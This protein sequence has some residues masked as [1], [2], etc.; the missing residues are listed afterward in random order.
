MSLFL[1]SPLLQVLT[2]I[3]GLT[4]I[5]MIITPTTF[6]IPTVAICASFFLFAY[7]VARKIKSVEVRELITE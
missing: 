3:I 6:I 5:E 4:R 1:T 7:I 2:K